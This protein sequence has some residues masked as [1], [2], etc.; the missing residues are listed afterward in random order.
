MRVTGQCF[1]FNRLPPSPWAYT[2]VEVDERLFVCWRCAIGSCDA[3]YQGNSEQY[4]E[5]IEYPCVGNS[6][7]H[8]DGCYYS[9]GHSPEIAFTIEAPPMPF[10]YVGRDVSSE[11]CSN[12]P[13][14]YF[15]DVFQEEPYDS[16][17]NYYCDRNNI[18]TAYLCF[19]T[20]FR[21]DIFQINIIHD[22]SR[23]GINSGRKSRH[24]SCQ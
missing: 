23:C 14:E 20:R 13:L 17:D 16:A 7:L 24:E 3:S 19:H 10:Q 9:G 18:A 12:N 15:I 4:G 1:F 22:I 21:I 6:E 8:D 2:G 11:E 5:E